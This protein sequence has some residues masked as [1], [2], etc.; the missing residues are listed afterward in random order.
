VGNDYNN[1]GEPGRASKY[2]TKAFQLREHASEREKLEI[3]AD[4]YSNV[5]GELDKVAQTYK[6]EIES[7][8][9]DFVPYDN[10]GG[11]YSQQGQ[12]VKAAEVTRQAMR[13]T[14]RKNKN[15]FSRVCR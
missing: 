15:R 13:L 7:Y 6:E 11:A 5:T 9:R 1:L 4:Y 14:Y 10:L 8:P 12:Y 2:Y 3:T